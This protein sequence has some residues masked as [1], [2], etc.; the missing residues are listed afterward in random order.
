MRK[1]TISQ[2]IAKSRIPSLIRHSVSQETVEG[3][4]ADFLI[5]KDSKKTF[6]VIYL[7][8]DYSKQNPGYISFKLEEVGKEQRKMEGSHKTLVLVLMES[9]EETR[10]MSDVQ[11]ECLKKDVNLML[12]FE[13][14][15]VGQAIND[16]ID[17]K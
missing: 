15:E 2:H 7:P 8:L 14:R 3:Q 4:A 12:C 6:S 1:I 16:I 9:N 11:S 10:H 17:I 13:L 5:R